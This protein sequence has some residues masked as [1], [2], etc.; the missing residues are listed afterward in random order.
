MAKAKLVAIGDSL[1]QGFQ[2]FA[3]SDTRSSYPALIAESLGAREAFALPD[4]RGSGGLPLNLEWLARRLEDRFGADIGMFEWFRSLHVIPE[5]IS[6]VEDYWE[7]GRGAAPIADTLYHNLAV[8]GFEA[9]DAYGLT[10]KICDERIGKPKDD[11]FSPPS[12]PR[13]RT[14]RRVLNPAQLAERNTDTQLSVARKIA[15]QQGGI[16]HLIVALGSNNCLGTVVQLRV[17]ETSN[18]PPGVCSKFTLWTPAAFATEYDRLA[19]E[20]STI[21]ADHVYVAT[22]PHVTIPPITRG[23]MKSR[24]SLPPGEKYFDFYTR[25]W[26]HDKE[27]DETRDPKLTKAE[28]IKIDSYIDQYNIHIRAVAAARGFHVVDM[29]ALLDGLAVRRNHGE[30]TFQLPPALSDLSTRLFETTP[31]GRI[32]S[33]GLISL[34]GVHPTAC[35]YALI[36]Q[37]FIKVMKANGTAPQA[38]DIDFARVRRGD[39]LVSA[40]PRTLDDM[41]GALRTLEEHFHIS[42]WLQG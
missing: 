42:G 30:P 37:E 9:G 32:K 22:V 18:E 21:G 15:Q 26:I 17:L 33:G 19:Q 36:A 38:L 11:W 6:E 13:L 12:E 25:F 28:A 35:G 8:W 3:I 4:F 29:C 40:A 14:A 16:E 27:F 1:T 31:A 34:D 23:I 39:T 7:R 5:L 24:G 10:P 20:V 2:S 41:L